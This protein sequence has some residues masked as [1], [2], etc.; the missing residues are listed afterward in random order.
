MSI[1]FDE[2]M[3]PE[4]AKM[5]KALLEPHA[6]DKRTALLTMREQFDQ[7]VMKKI[8]NTAKQPVC[9]EINKIGDRKE[10]GGVFYE[11]DEA[12]WKRLPIGT[13]L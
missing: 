4:A 9:L 5:I 2:D 12:G 7:Q 3:N 8:A 13:T 1:T 11:L 10:V 6:M